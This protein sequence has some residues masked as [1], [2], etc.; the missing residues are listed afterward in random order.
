MTLPAQPAQVPAHIP[1]SGASL[2]FGLDRLV[3]GGVRGVWVRGTLPEGPVVWAANHHSW[4]D[5]FVAV[6]LLRADARDFALLMDA[7]NLE[8]FAF[9]RRGGAIGTANLRAAVAAL[10]RGETVVVFPEAELLPPGPL[11]PVHSGA[12]WLARQAPATLV[13]VALRVINRGHQWPEVYVDFTDVDLLDPTSHTSAADTK[14]HI[15]PNA[16][17]N[18]SSDTKHH[19]A[20]HTEPD[21]A[22][23]D[24]L[25]TRLALLDEELRTA[26]PRAPLPGFDLVVPGRHSWDERIAGIAARVPRRGQS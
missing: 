8:A 24:V 6:S 20:S 5:G 1:R 13:A 22:L 7:E 23:V 3:R 12:Q 16:G 9:L 4:W 26:D 19:A 11:G 15:G 14:S 17:P 21:A 18:T 25:G 10:R 2:R